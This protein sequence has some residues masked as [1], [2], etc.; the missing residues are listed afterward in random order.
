MSTSPTPPVPPADSSS[1][2]DRPG[3]GGSELSENRQPASASGPLDG[4]TDPNDPGFDEYEELTPELVED[5]AI[6]GDF[7]IK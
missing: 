7:V 6:R 1:A 5:E 4:V 2:S 3:V